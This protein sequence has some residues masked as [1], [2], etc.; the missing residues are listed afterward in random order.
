MHEFISKYGTQLITGFIAICG[1]LFGLFWNQFFAWRKYRREQKA[2]LNN[3][4]FHLLELYFF[5]S[6]LDFTSFIQIYLIQME[7]RFG[8]IPAEERAQVEQVIITMIKDKVNNLNDEEEI[9]RLSDHYEAAVKEVAFINPF[10]AYRL[11][12]QSKR[13]GHLEK[14]NGYFDS[15]RELM[16]T[17]AEQ[18]L[19]QGILSNYNDDRFIKD[20]IADVKDS[21]TEISKE[22]GLSKHLEAKKYFIKQEK[23]MKED[24]EDEVKQII[25]QLEA[26]IPK[27][28]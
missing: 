26:Q 12:G 18:K 7:K 23:T 1:I 11:A 2:K 20:M 24:V 22:I 6:R 13:I 15:I 21:I 17:E 19:L 3:L 4:L 5:V 28:V 25:D 9:E 8:A 16:S 14:L 27:N 10:L